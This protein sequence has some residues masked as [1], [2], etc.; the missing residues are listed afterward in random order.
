MPPMCRRRFP[1]LRL[2]NQ[3]AYNLRQSSTLGC[4]RGRIGERDHDHGYRTPQGRARYIRAR[5]RRA[6]DGHRRHLAPRL[7]HGRHF[8]NRRQAHRR[9]LRRGAASEG[10]L[11]AA[12]VDRSRLSPL[13]TGL[14]QWRPDRRQ[15]PETRRQEEK[16]RTPPQRRRPRTSEPRAPACRTSVMRSTYAWAMH[17]SNHRDSIGHDKC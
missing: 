10:I 13:R 3:P 6:Y 12:V 11:P 4:G 1:D 7:H 17:R 16:G 9:R 2:V 14:G 5:H 8:G 15:F